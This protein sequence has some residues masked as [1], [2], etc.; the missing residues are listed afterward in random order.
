[1]DDKELDNLDN[2]PEEEPEEQQ[3]ETNVD[4]DW[5]DQSMIIIDGSNPDAGIPNPRKDAAAIKRA[6]TEDKKSLLREMGIRINKKDSP[7]LFERLKVTINRKGKPNGAE[8]DGVKIIE[9]KGKKLEYTE[10]SKVSEFKELVKRAEEKHAKTTEGFVEESIS[11]VP[12]SEE[13]VHSVI[14]NSIENLDIIIDKNVEEVESGLNDPAYVI[15]EEEDREARGLMELAPPT[16]L[17]QGEISAEN[18]IAYA[19]IEEAKWKERFDNEENLK[20]KAPYK[21][22]VKLAKLKADYL[23][24]SI[25]QRPESEEVQICL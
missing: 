16:E 4:T 21:S 2:K 10:A 11:D 17:Q 19:K 12:A 25:N 9:L 1:M 14:R 6:Y 24:L 7:S 3:E 18:K 23:R 15:T 22:L 20:K 5:R 13:L 8:F